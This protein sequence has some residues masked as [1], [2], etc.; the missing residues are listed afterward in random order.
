MDAVD[1]F[2]PEEDAL[3]DLD[4]SPERMAEINCVLAASR[5]E[6]EVVEV[7]LDAGVDL[8]AKDV[9]GTTALMAASFRGCTELVRLLVT[10]GASI[11]V[12]QERYRWT[13]LIAAAYG[14]HTEATRVLIQC[15]ADME[16]SD[17][18]VRGGVDSSMAWCAR[19]GRWCH[20]RCQ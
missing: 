6:L 5:G 7:A 20:C 17:A 13:P 10:R 19:H 11:N 2:P 18:E 9:D 1:A 4:L 8:D 14:D 12:V 15:G 16:F 3:Q